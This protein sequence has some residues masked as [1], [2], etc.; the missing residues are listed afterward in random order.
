MTRDRW[1]S[2]EDAA[3]EIG[4]VTPRWVR[5]QVEEGRLRARVL[6]TGQRPTYRIREA[7]LRTFRARYVL[8]DARDRDGWRPADKG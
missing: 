5:K 4:G 8:E 6:L 3:R 1:F 2:T 7:D